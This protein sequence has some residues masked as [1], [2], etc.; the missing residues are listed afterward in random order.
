MR[1]DKQKGFAAIAFFMLIGLFVVISALVFFL[2]FKVHITSLAVDVIS[3]NRY[4]EIPTTVLA[5][6][7]TMDQYDDEKG[8]VQC[9]TGNGPANTHD[10]VKDLCTKTVPIL[11]S[12]K[13]NEF[14]IYILEDKK[15]SLTGLPL[16][17]TDALNLFRDNLRSA[18]PIDCYEYSFEY[19]GTEAA[20]EGRGRN[21]V[22]KPKPFSDTLTPR[23][24]FFKLGCG[25][26]D[27][28]KIRERYPIPIIIGNEPA[29]ADQLMLIKSSSTDGEGFLV[30]WPRFDSQFKGEN[31]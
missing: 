30:T 14:P 1:E 27:S 22:E 28:P 10:P 19:V 9:F 6:G 11:F 16:P 21:E 8:E 2:T 3:V 4:Q 20:V 15:E 26:D 13:V 31:D 12:K 17:A 23:N 5:T 18:L 25:D 24:D 29:V 7:V